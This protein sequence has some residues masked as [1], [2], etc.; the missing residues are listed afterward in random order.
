[1][2]DHVFDAGLQLQ[3]SLLAA[4]GGHVFG[5]PLLYAAFRTAGFLAGVG[6][7]AGAFAIGGSD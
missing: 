4:F 3:S 5:E 6:Q 2:P 7:V 1:V